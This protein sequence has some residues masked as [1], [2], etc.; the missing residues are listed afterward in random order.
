MRRIGIGMAS[1]AL[2]A[3]ASCVDTGERN[4]FLT[5]TETFSTQ[6]SRNNNSS[7]GGSGGTTTAAFR[8]TMGLTLANN[9]DTADLNVSV[10]AWVSPASIRTAE[11]QDAL[12]SAGYVQL[13][14]ELRLGAVF[15]LVPGTF[16]LNGPGFAG[17]IRRTIPA[18]GTAVETIITPDVVLV[19]SQP[20]V[21]CDSEAFTFSVDGE[22]LNSVPV[23]GDIFSGSTN[24]GG[25]KTYAQINV[26]QC[27]PLRPGLFLKIG[28][29]GREQNQFFE[30]ES[31][32]VDF[33]QV[34]D[35]VGNF[36]IV[37]IGG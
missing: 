23:A 26:Y 1:V 2:L 36:G 9:H 30:G 27:T 35:A 15:T 24:A 14:S 34:P 19:F 4:P 6:S 17:A 16:V 5:F 29:G 10:A 25:R 8:R 31:I 18:G 3:L 11:Q 33:N 12:L 22:V 37:T 20:P 21:G 28:G 32:R 13:T 7:G